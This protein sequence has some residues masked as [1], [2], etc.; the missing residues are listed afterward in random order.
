M[1]ISFGCQTPPQERV[2]HPVG[3]IDL[4]LLPTQG[5]SRSSFVFMGFF[6][7]SVP[8]LMN[9]FFGQKRYMRMEIKMKVTVKLANT[10]KILSAQADEFNNSFYGPFKGPSHKGAGHFGTLGKEISYR[11]S[12]GNLVSVHENGGSF[13]LS[14]SGT[15][16]GCLNALGYVFFQQSFNPASAT[17]VSYETSDK[18][19]KWFETMHDAI[20]RLPSEEILQNLAAK[21]DCANYSTMVKKV[22]K[23]VDRGLSIRAL[24]ASFNT[25]EMRVAHILMN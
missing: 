1:T 10:P 3:T 18:R 25:T 22:S 19:L 7:G 15:R 2:P 23:Q 5:V 14:L 4:R 12:S 11:T 20:D 16:H 9:P 24:A 13:Y 21:R 8:R 6:R 17:I